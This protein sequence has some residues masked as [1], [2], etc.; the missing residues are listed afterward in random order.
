MWMFRSALFWWLDPED[1][2]AFCPCVSFIGGRHRWAGFGGS[3][4]ELVKNTAG[5]D[6]L[7]LSFLQCHAARGCTLS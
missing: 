5:G 3:V 1:V 6:K 7:G 2:V 4:D